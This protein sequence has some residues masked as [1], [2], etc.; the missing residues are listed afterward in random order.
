MLNDNLDSLKAAANKGKSI[1]SRVPSAVIEGEME[2]GITDSANHS[3]SKIAI[4]SVGDPPANYHT[5]SLA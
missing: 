3:K 2:K 1:L 5:A 4:A